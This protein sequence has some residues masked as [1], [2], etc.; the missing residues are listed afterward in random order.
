M[1]SAHTFFR[2]AALARA[3]ISPIGIAGG[4]REPDPFK[5]AWVRG[6]AKLYKSK[7]SKAQ[8]ELPRST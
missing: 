4:D 7:M 1:K 2:E 3:T 8:T 5:P 6:A